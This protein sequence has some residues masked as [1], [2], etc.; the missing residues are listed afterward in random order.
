MMEIETVI[1]YLA[2]SVALDG[3]RAEEIKKS[4]QADVTQELAHA[5]QLAN[6]IKTIGGKIPGS[7][8]MQFHQASLQP[9]DDL[10]DV[11]HV[12]KGVIEAEDAAVH[13]Y[14]HVIRLCEGVDYVTQDLCI[15][16]LGE[17]EMHRREFLGF[18]KE[19]EKQP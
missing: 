19:Y 16:L 13:Q 18:L 3:V 7:Q 6:R 2:N 10:T 5:Q 1:N 17:E 12:I 15:G 14:N 9:P 8:A 4:L 11:V